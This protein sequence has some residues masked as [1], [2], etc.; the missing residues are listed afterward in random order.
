MGSPVADGADTRLELIKSGQK[1]SGMEVPALLVAGTPWEGIAHVERHK[2]SE[3]PWE[4]W[5]SNRSDMGWGLRR[6]YM[7]MRRFRRAA[8]EPLAP[9]A[10]RKLVR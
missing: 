10:G 9:W 4:K 3:R 6:R 8:I 5:H 7:R 2:V 1:G